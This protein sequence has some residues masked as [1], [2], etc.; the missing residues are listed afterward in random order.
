MVHNAV[1]GDQ[2]A[3]SAKQLS[4]EFLTSESWAK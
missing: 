1:Y 2:A 3:M 4:V